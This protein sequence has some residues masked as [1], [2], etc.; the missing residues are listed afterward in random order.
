MKHA[1]PTQYALAAAKAV[2]PRGL[3]LD[4]SHAKGRCSFDARSP[5]YNHN[6]MNNKN[7]GG[8]G[9]GDR[10]CRSVLG[11]DGAGEGGAR[12][13]ATVKTFGGTT[14]RVVAYGQGDR[15]GI[16]WRD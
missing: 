16:C 15:G 7:S 3:H 13:G 11:G 4:L 14:V 5:D 1:S 10:L 6:N 12:G 8:G 9:G 2:S